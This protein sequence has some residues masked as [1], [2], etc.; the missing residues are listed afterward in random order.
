[1]PAPLYELSQP[2]PVNNIKITVSAACSRIRPYVV[3]AVLR[4]VTF[5]KDRYDSFID[6]QDK[7]HQN[8]CQRWT[9]VAIGTHDLDT[10]Q[11]PFTY[12]AL[13]PKDIV[14]TPSGHSEDMGANRIIRGVPGPRSGVRGQGPWSKVQSLC[15]PR[16]LDLLEIFK[17]AYEHAPC[18]VSEYTA[19]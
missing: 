8:I 18:V 6:L 14:F 2:K 13:P 12:E 3:G 4:G 9:L 16:Y 15:L 7:L 5:D 1:M 19:I 11:P 10:I 17:D